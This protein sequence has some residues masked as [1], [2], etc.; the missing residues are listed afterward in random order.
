MAEPKKKTKPAAENKKVAAKK[1]DA[2]KP[3]GADPVGERR[4]DPAADAT[5]RDTDKLDSQGNEKVGE[6]GGPNIGP[7]GK[8]VPP[9]SVRQEKKTPLQQHKEDEAAKTVTDGIDSIGNEQGPENPALGPRGKHSSPD[10][11]RR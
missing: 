6:I 9:D 8:N 2:K 1:A 7:R 11:F 5:P 4:D 10:T 3:E